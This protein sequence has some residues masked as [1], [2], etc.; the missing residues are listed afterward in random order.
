MGRARMKKFGK[1]IL[2][3]MYQFLHEKNPDIYA[4]P[5]AYQM[6]K[7]P[8]YMEEM[9]KMV[10]KGEQKDIVDKVD[11]VQIRK[12]KNPNTMVPSQSL[13]TDSG[14]FNVQFSSPSK[15][16]TRADDDSDNI[17]SRLS[18]TPHSIDEDGF[19]RPKPHFPD[20]GKANNYKSNLARFGIV[21][22]S[23]DVSPNKFPFVDA[24]TGQPSRAGVRSSPFAAASSSNTSGHTS[25][26]ATSWLSGMSPGKVSSR[27][28]TPNSGTK[29]RA[30][31]DAVGS[32]EKRQRPS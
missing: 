27:E 16:S 19:L 12:K 18:E 13:S 20:T 2:C 22:D 7:M 30:E 28:N 1:V 5:D 4:I 14:T 8:L 32:A 15:S 25:G 26:V 24:K 17:G 6:S 9:Q 10:N 11:L 29:R 23:L 21:P 31:D 3:V